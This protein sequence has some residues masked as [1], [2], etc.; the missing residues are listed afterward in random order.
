[1]THSSLLGDLIDLNEVLDADRARELDA[2]RQRDRRIGRTLQGQRNKPV[3]QL[4]AWLHEMDRAALRNTG[5]RGTRLYH[6]L[7]LA[8]LLTGV[9]TGWGVA[10]AVLF[11]DGKQPVNIVNAVAVLVVPQ[12]LLLLVWLL[13]ALPVRVPLFVHLRGTFGFLNPGRLAARLAGLFGRRE[14]QGLATL[15]NPDNSAVLAPAARWLFSFWS[16]FFAFGFNIGVLA[17]AAFLI[18]FS[19]MAFVWSTTLTVSNETFQQWLALLA[20]PWSGVFPQAVPDAALIANSRYYRFEEGSLSGGLAVELGQWWPFLIAAITC[21]GLLP[22]VLT[23]VFSW[24]RLRHHLRRALCNLPGAPELLARMNS[25]L[26]STLAAEP[27]HA[28][29]FAAAGGA[30]VA[31]GQTQYA[32]RG[33]VIDWSGACAEAEEVAARLAP[34]GIQAQEFLPAGGRRSTEE[35]RELVA[36]LCRSKPEGVAIL[37]KAWE[38]PML[39]F[40]DFVRGVRR[41]CGHRRPVI[42]L[43]WGGADGVSASDRDTW[44]LTLGQLGDPDLHVEVVGRAA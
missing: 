10:S 4:R 41:Q 38:P 24:Y 18:T 26:I 40:L 22:R 16:Q 34:T 9:L 15:W 21:Y 2:R 11:Y 8:L 32:L 33:P 23:L 42:V 36:A 13:S 25:P 1:M 27:E 17:G 3:R 39:D 29:Q 37:V 5:A 20:A 19:D 31:H 7:G 35:D 30:A 6:T 12:I 44:Q 14:N 28:M 43:L